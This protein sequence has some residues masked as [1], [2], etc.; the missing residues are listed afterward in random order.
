[1]L[2][3]ETGE[4]INRMVRA[5]SQRTQRRTRRWGVSE[6]KFSWFHGFLIKKPE[7]RS[8]SFLIPKFFKILLGKPREPA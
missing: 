7:F 5:E 4:I 6:H 2:P 8:P 3:N 1:M